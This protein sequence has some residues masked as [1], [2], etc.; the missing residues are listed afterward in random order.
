M[1]TKTLFKFVLSAL[2]ITAAHSQVD[3]PDYTNFI[4]QIQLG[5]GGVTY[6]LPAAAA[7]QRLSQEQINSTGARFE[8]HTMKN[9][10]LQSF[11]LGT[12]NVG[13]FVPIAQVVI[14]TQDTKST[15]PRTRV[16]KGFKVDINI[17]GLQSGDVPEAAKKVKLYHYNQSYGIDGIGDNLD[18][19]QAT[20]APSVSLEENKVY[21]LDFPPRTAPPLSKDIKY[22]GEERFS[23]NSLEDYQ[24]GMEPLIASQ[25]VQIWPIATGTIS[26]I[27][28]GQII[29]FS[30]P[31]V[32][33]AIFDLYPSSSFYAQVY[34]GPKRDGVVGTIVPGSP[35]SPNESVPIDDLVPVSDWDSVLT[36]NGEWTMELLT[37]HPF[38]TPVGTDGIERLAS[39]SFNVDRTITVNGS[40]TTS[41]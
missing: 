8:L 31:T 38:G 4:R 33:L 27:T 22:R 14:T 17:Q 32:T 21:S 23:V 30:T 5:E 9:D 1:K 10:T 13:T 16:D 37:T 29:E 7:G 25:T 28:E 20:T 19:T 3:N 35:R 36:A 26:G 12:Q 40:V 39:V 41:E 2:M 24:V 34:P 6:Q 11:L 18:R 15:V